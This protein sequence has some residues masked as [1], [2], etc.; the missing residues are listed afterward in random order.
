MAF[1]IER[2]G[3]V[4]VYETRRDAEEALKN[5]LEGYHMHGRDVRRGYWWARNKESPRFKFVISDNSNV[6]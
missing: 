6:S 3:P 1:V 4:G 2:I 5:L